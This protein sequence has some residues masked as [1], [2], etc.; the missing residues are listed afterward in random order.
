MKRKPHDMTRRKMVL[1][2]ASKR[3]VV[4]RKGKTAENA[5]HAEHDTDEIERYILRKERW[6]R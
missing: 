3:V 4:S 1:C 6:E 2:F 5:T